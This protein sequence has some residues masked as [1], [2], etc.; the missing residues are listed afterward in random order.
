MESSA[1]RLFSDEKMAAFIRA[2]G[3]PWA[4]SRQQLFKEASKFLAADEWSE[5]DYTAFDALMNKRTERH[6][7]SNERDKAE[8]GRVGQDEPYKG[9]LDLEF[10]GTRQVGPVAQGLVSHLPEPVE[11]KRDSELPAAATGRRVRG[12]S[13]YGKTQR[14]IRREQARKIADMAK[15]P[16]AISKKFTRGQLAAMSAIVFLFGVSVQNGRP[17][18]PSIAAVAEISR[19]SPSTIKDG[20]ARGKHLGIIE[21]TDRGKAPSEFVV[22]DPRILARL[23]YGGDFSYP[24]KPKRE[25]S[26]IISNTKHASSEPRICPTDAESEP[27]AEV[28]TAKL[29]DHHVPKVARDILEPEVVPVAPVQDEGEEVRQEEIE[30]V[31]A[32]MARDEAGPIQENFLDRIAREAKEAYLA[33]LKGEPS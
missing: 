24:T 25:K 6:R 1:R 3:G 33:T 32:V 12:R 20:I 31:V 28:T 4:T 18:T 30:E 14:S 5:A 9:D 10:E 22:R 21:V 19:V 11:P 23:G 15:I 13:L 17:C 29:S 26:S 7:A 8:T 2:Q 27:K 16:A